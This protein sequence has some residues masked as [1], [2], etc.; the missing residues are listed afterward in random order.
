MEA[1]LEREAMAVMSVQIAPEK[2]N[3][4]LDDT[5]Y[6]LRDKNGSIT[7]VHIGSKQV[8]G[9]DL[10]GQVLD[11]ELARLAMAKALEYFEAKVLCKKRM[12]WEACRVIRKPRSRCGG[13]T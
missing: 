4:D 2:A 9:D 3:A 7:N 5:V 11:A 13:P 10:T 6:Q 8:S 1:V 12:M